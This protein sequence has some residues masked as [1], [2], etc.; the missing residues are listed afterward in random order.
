[1]RSGPTLLDSLKSALSLSKTVLVL[2]PGSLMLLFWRSFSSSGSL[3]LSRHLGSLEAIVSGTTV[4]AQATRAN[5][6]G[7]NVAWVANLGSTITGDSQQAVLNSSVTTST[8]PL[9]IIDVVPETA[10]SSGSF[11]EVLVI[12]NSG[13]HSYRYNTGI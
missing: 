9:K 12:W 13:I 1:M 2:L 8:V 6:V 11:S 10:N 4:V 7:G 3:V 5:L